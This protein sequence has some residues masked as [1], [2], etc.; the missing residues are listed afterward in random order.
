MSVVS[1]NPM[2]SPP[3]K[4]TRRSHCS[5]GKTAAQVSRQTTHLPGE[6]HVA[7]KLVHQLLQLRPLAGRHRGEHR[8]GGRHAL[9]ELFEELVEVLRITGEQV[10]VLLP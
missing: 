10:A 9:G 6:V 8:R 5:P 4:D 2:P 7:Q 3:L 1:A